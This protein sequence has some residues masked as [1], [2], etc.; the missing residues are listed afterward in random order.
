MA[1]E[2]KENY[3][4]WTLIT[5]R[6]AATANGKRLGSTDPISGKMYVFYGEAR[7]E[8]SSDHWIFQNLYL[9]IEKVK[10]MLRLETVYGLNPA[11]NSVGKEKTRKAYLSVGYRIDDDKELND[12]AKLD[13]FLSG[14]IPSWW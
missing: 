6:D 7:K 2:R 13:D 12:L 8:L 5:G 4:E 9:K 10:E 11:Y 1:H 14:H 3:G